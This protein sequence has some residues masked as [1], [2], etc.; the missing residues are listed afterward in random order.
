MN[1]RQQKKAFK[2]KYG[3]NPPKN[4]SIF[5]AS[6]AAEIINNNRSTWENTIN[7]LIG[8]GKTMKKVYEKIL[9]AQMQDNIIKLQ[10]HEPK[11]LE[12]ELKGNESNID[13]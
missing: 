11:K 2:K 1:K 6:S 12:R 7:I 5:M 3:V 10:S 13:I 4:I 8:L 9:E